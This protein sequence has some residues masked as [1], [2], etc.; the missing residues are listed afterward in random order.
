MN[1]PHFPFFVL[2]AFKSW[3]AGKMGLTVGYVTLSFALSVLALRTG[4]MF[5]LGGNA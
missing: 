1:L 3:E 4:I 5:V 2:D